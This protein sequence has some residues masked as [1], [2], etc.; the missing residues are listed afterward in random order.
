MR[1]TYAHGVERKEKEEKTG[2]GF[3]PGSLALY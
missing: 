3:E 1:K 2:P